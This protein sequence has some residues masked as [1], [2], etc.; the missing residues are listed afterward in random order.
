MF[1]V[2]HTVHN[3]E[4]TKRKTRHLCSPTLV[5]M[6]GPSRCEICTQWK[7]SSSSLDGLE[8]GLTP[9]SEQPDD[10]KG[11]SLN[12]AVQQFAQN[13]VMDFVSLIRKTENICAVLRAGARLADTDLTYSRPVYLFCGREPPSTLRS[14]RSVFERNDAQ[15]QNRFL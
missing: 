11:S 3:S 6:P 15:N 14:S 1:K 8:I 5:S 13:R 4:S 2:L 12:H 7:K 9:Q 10:N